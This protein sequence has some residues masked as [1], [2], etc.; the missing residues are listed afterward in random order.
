[1]KTVAIL[2]FLLLSGCSANYTTESFVYQDEQPEKQ[3]NITKIQTELIEANISAVVSAVS[4]TA[5]DGITLRG[6]KLV[7]QDA[8][9]NIVFFSANGMKVSTSS[10]ILN[11]FSLLPANVIWFDYRGMGVSDKK[12][13]LSLNSLRSD[14]LRIFDFS[15][16][17]FPTNLQTIIHGLSMGSLVAS[18]VA[19]NKEIDALI[20]DGAISTVPELVDNL[21]PTWSKPFYSVNLSAELAKINNIDLI[22]EYSKP[23]LFLI[24]EDDSTTPVVNSKE[25]YNISSS[26]VKVLAIIPNT[27]H[28]ETMRKDKAIKA[29]QDFINK[30]ICCKNG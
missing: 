17:E 28:G 18:Y 5:E 16:G 20:L 10:K 27:E 24:G 22:K 26:L 14:A 11:K 21:M 25:L 6:V 2:F 9:V 1:M 4:L 15:K 30:L 7:N 13:N 12:E 19:G 23:L 8:L 29:Y 3:L